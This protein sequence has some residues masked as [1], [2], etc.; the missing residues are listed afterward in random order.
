MILS[1]DLHE[2][3]QELIYEET[4]FLRH[5]MGQVLDNNDP[6]LLGRVKVSITELGFDPLLGGDGLWCFPRQLSAMIVPKI[7]DFVE[8]YFMKSENEGSLPVYL[9]QAS[10]MKDM[11]PKNYKGVTTD[12]VIFED[13]NNQNNNIKLEAGVLKLMNGE[14]ESFVLGDTLKTE[15]QKNVDA[16]TQLQTDLNSW[17]PVP[18]DGGAAL[19]TI[20][21]SGFLTKT[22]ASLTNIL[23]L[24]IKG[25]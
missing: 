10:E 6:D 3:I 24:L 18:N 5:F 13:R 21:S 1:D 8:V 20:L 15:L 9:T 11:I 17:T 4:I 23:S 7:G 16:L 2:M 19:K 25:A 22:I 14:S 12:A